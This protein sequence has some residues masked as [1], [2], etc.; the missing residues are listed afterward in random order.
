MSGR[1]DAGMADAPFALGAVNS[2]GD[3][4]AVAEL[5]RAYADGLGVDLSYQGFEAELAGLPG[6]YAPPAGALLLARGA[7][8]EPLGCVGMR[9]LAVD[10]CCE[11]KRL[12]VAAEGRGLGLGRALA[13]AIVGAA[14][15]AGYREMRLDTLPAMAAALALYRD[16]GFAP[17]A[18]YYDTPVAGTR[19]LAKP[20]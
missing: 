13:E 17:I 7:R 3:L 15:L 9:P 18:P 11:M 5:F 19:F 16:L 2:P 14:A 10:G 4:A 6:P 1:Q 20:L 8:G 12:Y